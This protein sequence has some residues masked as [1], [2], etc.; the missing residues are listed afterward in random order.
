MQ[1]P[2]Y[3]QYENVASSIS[4]PST[5]H[6]HNTVLQRFF[7]RYL[8]QDA[9]SVFRW[10]FPKEWR[11]YK[12]YVKYALYCIGYLGVLETDKYGVIPQ[13]CGLYGYDI[14][15][16]PSH[17]IVSNAFL[18]E[19]VYCRIDEEGVLL[20][21][22]PDYGSIL[23]L[24][25]FYA[26]MMALC[27]ETIG[28]NI[29]N[30]KL[31]YIFAASSKNDAESFKKMFDKVAS[32]EPA[33]FIGKDLFNEDGSPN[34]M[35]FN[36]DLKNTYVADEI[37]IDLRKWE[38]EF[39][40]DLGINNANTEKKERMIVDEVASNNEETMLWSDLTLEQLKKDC[41]KARELFGIEL[42]VDYRF[43]QDTK[44]NMGQLIQLP[45][46]REVG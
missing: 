11:N 42:D 28:T 15:F 9:M 14:C 29:L 20:K 21:L 30:S 36:Q 43:K 6:I 37:M 26:D 25:N 34:W 41:K 44:D 16:Q 10:R 5:V 31:S 2:I 24:V 32:G 35:Q 1:L 17:F 19:T 13:V 7:A 46:R 12:N 39:C 40:R 23:D 38:Q 27:A 45:E 33:A 3:Y 4:Q 22:Q 18:R 8:L